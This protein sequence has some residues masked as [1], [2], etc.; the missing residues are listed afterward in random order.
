[1][2]VTL[3]EPAMI[4]RPG[5]SEKPMFCFQPLTLGLLAGITPPDI[6]V[7]V[8]DDR[9]DAIDF[10]DPT[11]LVGISVKT[12][13]ARRAYEIAAEYRARGVKVVLGGYHPSLVPEEA[14]EHA[15]TVVI[16]EAESVWET[17]LDDLSRQELGRVY[18][19][20]RAERYPVGCVKRSV[21][22]ARKYIPIT[23]V[24]TS[25]GCPYNCSFC[26]VT[27]FSGHVYRQRTPQSILRE[28]EEQD[29]HGVFFVDD[30][31]VGDP[32]SAKALFRAL[33]PL[34]LQWIGEASIS[35][36]N[37]PELM[38]LMQKSGCAGVLVGL[39]SI[40]PQSLKQIHKGWNIKQTY[41]ESLR[42]VREH[43]IAMIGSF[44]IGLD[45]DTSESLAETLEFAID[46]KLFAALFNLLVPYPGT[47]LYR[48]FERNG[49]LLYP[50]WWLDPRYAY[51][52]VSFRPRHFSAD[53]L[54]EQRLELYR[55]FYGKGSIVRRMIDLEANVRD[56]WH[57]FSY[58]SLN[59]PAYQQELQRQG[60]SLGTQKA[61]NDE[62]VA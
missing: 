59:L 29:T 20:E 31:I 57:L 49:R 36:T 46:Q 18:R 56:L 39:E 32:D 44:I 6:Q 30:N 50:R 2:K 37:D 12:F 25:R 17:L 9:F 27:A 19:G 51:G 40:V 58:L 1:M 13:T 26:A 8:L 24:E 7:E 14:L 5:W 54:A 23:M 48:E 28:I 4:K 11:D 60:K 16:G 53:E 52:K 42:M 62:I 33:I 22:A 10:D 47:N 34:K 35:M 38:D 3:I 41:A 15:D 61:G 21:F 45:H 55:R 43:G